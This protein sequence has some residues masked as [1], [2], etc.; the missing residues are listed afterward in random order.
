MEEG[1]GNK[2]L[3][4]K[5]ARNNNREG[6]HRRKGKGETMA[7]KGNKGRKKKEWETNGVLFLIYPFYEK[8]KLRGNR[9]FI[10]AVC[11]QVIQLGHPSV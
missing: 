9:D 8:D 7:R 3:I 11:R 2:R 6:L 5:G 10:R 1:K 4:G